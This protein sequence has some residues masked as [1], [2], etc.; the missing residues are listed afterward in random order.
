MLRKLCVLPIAIALSAC[1]SKPAPVIHT[2]SY[3]SKVHSGTVYVNDRSYGNSEK[4]PARWREA[5]QIFKNGLPPMLGMTLKVK[6]TVNDNGET[7]E[8]PLL[9]TTGH[10]EHVALKDFQVS[11]TLIIGAE[12][13][14]V[15]KQ[16]DLFEYPEGF[17]LRAA[18]PSV[19]G[20]E[21]SLCLGI[22]RMSINT[23]RTDIAGHPT[24]NLDRLNILFSGENNETQFFRFGSGEEIQIQ[25]AV[26]PQ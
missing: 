4:C 18:K 19:R 14:G 5:E 9:V 11:K 15:I 17:F 8:L 21:F 16:G 20:N 23:S 22:D 24:L 13:H 1:A 3:E 26:V 25:V 10:G 2:Y 12:T 6:V 7:R